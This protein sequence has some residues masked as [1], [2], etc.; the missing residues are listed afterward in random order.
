MSQKLFEIR[1]EED[2]PWTV[3]D[4]TADYPALVNGE[5]Q[6]GFEMQM[7]GEV[8]DLLNELGSLSEPS[9]GRWF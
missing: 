2:G 8:Q 6:A 1:K 7:A 5:V 3:Y 4:R 9:T